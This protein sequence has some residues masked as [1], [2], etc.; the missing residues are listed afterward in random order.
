MAESAGAVADK[1]ERVVPCQVR[2][3]RALPMWNN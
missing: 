2:E 1:G 3:V